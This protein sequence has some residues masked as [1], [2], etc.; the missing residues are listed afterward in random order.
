MS[1][2]TREQAEVER[3]ALEAAELD[4]SFVS[5]KRNIARYLNP[6]ADTVFPLEYSFHLLGDISGKRV[7]DFGCGTGEDAVVLAVRGA[8]VVGIDISPELIELARKRAAAN[9]VAADFLVGSAYQTGLPDESVDVVFIHAI[10]HHLDLE[11]SRREVL[12]VLRPGG[13]LIV[14]E[15]VRDSQ[16]LAF[17]RKLIPYHAQHV[18]E[19]EAPLTKKQLDAFCAGMTLHNLRRFRLLLVPLAKIF[20]LS[21]GKAYRMDGRLLKSFPW[22]ARYATVEVRKLTR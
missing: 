6:P 9:G 22:L 3:S 13:V 18:S 2:S 7:L 21:L 8:S 12:R 10:L 20:R 4:V 16:V 19:F 1:L 14:Q 11:Q 5:G 15:P 17:L